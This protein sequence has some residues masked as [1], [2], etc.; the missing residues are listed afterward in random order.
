MMSRQENMLKTFWRI[1]QPSVLQGVIGV[2]LMSCRKQAFWKWSILVPLLLPCFC[3]RQNGVILLVAIPPTYLEAADKNNQF[4]FH[5]QNPGRK[6]LVPSL[7]NH[8]CTTNLGWGRRGEVWCLS[9]QAFW[10]T[11][12]NALMHRV[13]HLSWKRRCKCSWQFGLIVNVA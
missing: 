6:Q 12:H 8:R 13:S 1:R 3:F 2:H 10:Q 7:I 4:R 9:C 5:F 11:R